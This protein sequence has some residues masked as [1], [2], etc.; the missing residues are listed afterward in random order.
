MFKAGDDGRRASV[1]TLDSARSTRVTPAQ[2]YAAGRRVVSRVEV[3]ELEEI[4]AAAERGQA[5][6][7]D[8]TLALVE[9]VRALARRTFVRFQEAADQAERADR[10]VAAL[11]DA[12]A[13][14]NALNEE[15]EAMRAERANLYT[16]AQ[17]G[18]L[19]AS[20]AELVSA[21]LKRRIE[22]LTQSVEARDRLLA[23]ASGDLEMIKALTFSPATTDSLREVEADRRTSHAA[24]LANVVR[25][26]R[27]IVGTPDAPP[28]GPDAA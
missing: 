24:H 22:E 10:A 23:T 11:S 16:A 4:E 9:T 1:R 20:E 26:I 6:R 3:G 14:I 18:D 8:R 21:P 27:G 5:L 13:R 2:A 17:V 28:S 7:P 25:D 12:Q 15:L 19:Q